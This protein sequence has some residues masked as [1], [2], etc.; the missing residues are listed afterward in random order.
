MWTVIGLV[1]W[2]CVGMLV[3]VGV[4]VLV[5]VG[6]WVGV[7]VQPFNPECSAYLFSSAHYAALTCFIHCLQLMGVMVFFPMWYAN[8]FSVNAGIGA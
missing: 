5:W 3:V 2:L 7:D 4:V 8:F 6:M 1:M